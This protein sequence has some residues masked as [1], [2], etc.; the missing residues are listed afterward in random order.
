MAKLDRSLDGITKVGVLTSDDNYEEL[1]VDFIDF[2]S[3]FYQLYNDS[4]LLAEFNS[5]YVIKIHYYFD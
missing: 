3:G 5:K 1:L 4:Q 2:E